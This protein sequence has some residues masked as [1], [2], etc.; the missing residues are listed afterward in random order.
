MTSTLKP[1]LKPIIAS[2]LSI[3]LAA[4]SHAA[5]IIADDFSDV[6]K[7]SSPATFGSWNTVNG[8]NTPTNSLTFFAAGDTA[9]SSD[10]GSELSFF[11]N[12][13]NPGMIDVNNNMTSGGWRTS[14]IL[15]L[16]ASTSSI[17]LTS[18][19]LDMRLT[20][21]TG[22]SQST[23]SKTGRMTLELVGSS[24]GV[25][26]TIDPGNSGY[27]TSDY[28]R[29]LDLSAL[30]TLDTSESYT[31]NIS[32][33]GTGFGHHK[34]LDAISLEGDITAIPEP[35]ALLLGAIGFVV[36]LRRRYA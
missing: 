19:S 7:T 33:L 12:A 34:A 13:A 35:S 5:V 17:E 8:I 23:S 25:L 1:A 6:L 9:S 20:N 27:P 21:G 22:G 36:L 2:T 29:V 4:G 28:T 32:A 10:D 11:N 26:G 31:I 3:V 16:D 15:V 30:P 14:I 24:S 18:I